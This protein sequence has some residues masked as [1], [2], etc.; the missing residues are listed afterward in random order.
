MKIA[1]AVMKPEIEASVAS[2]GA[3]APFYLLFNEKG[4]M[5]EVLSNP[6]I[7][8]GRGVAPLAAR[9][10]SGKGVTLLAA[11]DFGPRFVS[12]LKLKG[13]NHAQYSGKVSEIVRQLI[14]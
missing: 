5:L 14:A 9:L 1:V 11:G 7:E 13:I 12:E 4:E 2:H 10:L 8:L 3:R 6:Y